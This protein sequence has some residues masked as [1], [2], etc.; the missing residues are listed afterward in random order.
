MCVGECLVCV[1]RHVFSVLCVL[2]VCVCCMYVC[3]VS[4]YKHIT[5]L[6]C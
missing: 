2:Y 5:T 3:G 4:G 6:K 1:Y